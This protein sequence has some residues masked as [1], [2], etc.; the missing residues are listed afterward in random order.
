MKTVYLAG[1]ISGLIYAEATEWLD[2]A[3]TIFAEYDIHAKSPMRDKSHLAKETILTPHGYEVKPMS[4]Q[5]G[6]ITRDRNDVRTSDIVLMNLL[7]TTSVSIGSMV[8]IGWADAY[9]IPIV[10]V[11]NTSNPHDHAFIHGLSGFVVPTMEEAIEI[12]ISLLDAS[13]V[14]TE[15]RRKDRLDYMKYNYTP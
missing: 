8:E 3:K 5:K 11:L 4:S 14:V 7:N 10:T 6:I 12:V 15:G 9:R 2:K 13:N 1:P